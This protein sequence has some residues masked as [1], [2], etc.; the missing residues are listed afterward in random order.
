MVNLSHSRKRN[1]PIG[2]AISKVTL[3]TVDRL[4]LPSSQEILYA[5]S[6]TALDLLSDTNGRHLHGSKP[7]W[8]KPINCALKLGWMEQENVTS[9]ELCQAYEDPSP[10]KWSMWNKSVPEGKAGSMGSHRCLAQFERQCTDEGSLPCPPTEGVWA[11]TGWAQCQQSFSPRRTGQPAGY[12]APTGVFS[13]HKIFS[14]ILEPVFVSWVISHKNYLQDME[15]LEALRL[16]PPKAASVSWSHRA[17]LAGL[18]VPVSCCPAWAA[19]AHHHAPCPHQHVSLWPR[20]WSVAAP[21][22]LDFLFLTD[23]FVKYHKK[24]L[25]LPCSSDSEESACNAGDL[26]S[27]PGLGRSPGEGNGNPLQYSCLE[28]RMDRGAWRATVHGVAKSWTWL[29]D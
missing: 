25:D 3:G 9:E 1:W 14:E 22:T 20:M 18:R 13:L 10:R 15:G 19:C 4:T 2:E 8:W 26:G 12:I 7:S 16:H 21:G 17:S 28:N 27:I 23:T 24:E 5:T 6:G 29:S 11:E